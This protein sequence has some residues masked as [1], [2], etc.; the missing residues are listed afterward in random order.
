M[1][2]WRTGTV[3]RQHQAWVH[4]RAVEIRSLPA[5]F[6][7]CWRPLLLLLSASPKSTTARWHG[8]HDRR[9]RTSGPIH[10]NVFGLNPVLVLGTKEQCKAHVA[11]S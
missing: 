6:T 11:R 1:T 3:E 8:A 10:I 5:G 7:R 2:P 9:R 4:G